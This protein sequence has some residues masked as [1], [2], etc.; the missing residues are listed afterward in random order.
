MPKYFIVYPR[1]GFVDIITVIEKCLY[2][3]VK[4]N[5]LLIID[6]SGSQMKDD[7]Q[8]YINFNHPNI[9]VCNVANFYNSIRELSIYPREIKC[10]LDTIGQAHTNGIYMY[11]AE[12]GEKV[13]LRIDLTKDYFEDVVIYCHYRDG[14]I[15]TMIFNHIKI[16]DFII[17]EYNSRVAKLPKDYIS[18]HIR[19]TDYKSDVYSFIEI[20][21]QKMLSSPFF[22][23]SDNQN[24][25]NKIKSEFG[26]NVYTFSKGSTSGLPLHF[27]GGKSVEYKKQ[28]IIDCICDLLLLA[29]G[30]EIY[31]SQQ[32][33]GFSKLASYL[34]KNKDV[35]HNI[36]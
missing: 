23:A 36:L 31:C 24:D 18:F 12:S 28:N 34:Q 14:G 27:L 19:N 20:H 10:N 2:Y 22:L 7:I 35:L 30:V 4:Y 5:R 29:S 13:S 9:K 1:G 17:N 15:A 21:K 16:S 25:I 11:M 8:K 26:N 3:A 6:S 33:S 32:Y